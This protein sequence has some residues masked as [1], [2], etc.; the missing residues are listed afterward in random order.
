MKAI[1]NLEIKKVDTEEST[2]PDT[3]QMTEDDNLEKETA[4]FMDRVSSICKNK[5]RKIKA[6]SKDENVK[7]NLKITARKGNLERVP[8]RLSF[9]ETESPGIFL[10]TPCQTFSVKEDIDSVLREKLQAVNVCGEEIDHCKEKMPSMTGE[11]AGVF[12]EKR[13]F[14]YGSPSGV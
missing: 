8:N 1:K 14:S 6:T 3:H 9:C 11:G 2:E 5:S 10:K 12:Q 7:I 4:F 13:L